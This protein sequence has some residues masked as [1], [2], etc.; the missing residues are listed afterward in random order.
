[1]WRECILLV[2]LSTSL[3]TAYS[4]VKKLDQLDTL[5][6]E[7]EK[8]ERQAANAAEAAKRAAEAAANAAKIAKGNKAPTTAPATPAT[9]QD[10]RSAGSAPCLHH[11]RCARKNGPNMKGFCV[12]FEPV[13]ATSN[14]I[15]PFC[16][17]QK[18]G[19]LWG[20]AANNGGCSTDDDCN[21]YEQRV[22][23]IGQRTSD[24]FGN[25]AHRVPREAGCAALT[26]GASHW[27]RDACKCN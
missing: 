6:S 19:C 10:S 3:S 21:G 22:N 26:I 1:M 16:Y 13:D 25:P 20:A 11:I 7:V 12:G 5:L 2:A 17:G 24:K 4:T 9:Q 27:A 8:A 15:Q 14:D 23:F 18:N